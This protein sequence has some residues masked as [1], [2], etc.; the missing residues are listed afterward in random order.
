MTRKLLIAALP[1]GLALPFLVGGR[2]DS[3]NPIRGENHAVVERTLGYHLL[4][5]TS[6]PRGMVAGRAGV[7]T[8]ALRVLCDYTNDDDTLIIAQE[9][10]NPQRDAYNRSLFAGRTVDINGYEGRVTAGDLGE[11]RVTFYTPAVTIVLSS[12]T[13]SEQELVAVARSME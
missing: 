9:K 7:R 10:R 4:A 3:G 11:R 5:P 13:L 8:G 6:L 1:L 2:S 12:S